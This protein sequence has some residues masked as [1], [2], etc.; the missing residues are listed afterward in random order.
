[1]LTRSL[2]EGCYSECNTCSTQICRRPYL[3]G[4]VIVTLDHSL[5]WFNAGL[6]DPILGSASG[7]KMK[8]QS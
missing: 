6:L 1:M 4:H 3:D 8:K 5:I 7:V 2:L